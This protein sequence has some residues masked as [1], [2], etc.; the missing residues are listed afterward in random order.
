MIFDSVQ[1]V[2]D[3][4]GLTGTTYDEQIEIYMPVV[5]DDICDYLNNYFEDPIIYKQSAA[6]FEF[7]RGTTGTTDVSADYI[8]DTN[9]DFSTAGFTTDREFDICVRGGGGNAG[10]HHVASMTTA[11]GKMTLDSTGVLVDLDMDNSYQSPGAVRISLV[12]WPKPIRLIAAQMIWYLIKR[13]KETDVQ[14][15]RI[16]DYSI[17]Y[18]GSNAYPTRVLSGLAKYRQVVMV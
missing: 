4:L 5:Q 9:A 8:T 2:K 11:G 3:I 12:N 15:E 13:I 6:A 17:T 16:D 10:I 1:D 14:S 7:V 18:A